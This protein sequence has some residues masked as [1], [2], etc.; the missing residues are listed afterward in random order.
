LRDRLNPA[1]L[2]LREAE[3]IRAGVGMPEYTDAALDRLM[4][5]VHARDPAILA[6]LRYD[7]FHEVLRMER[8]RVIMD[9]DQATR[10]GL[11]ARQR[12]AERWMPPAR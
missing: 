6:D 9:A 11:D 10:A 12:A 2:A 5:R 7:G 3:R 4:E 1:R 8:L